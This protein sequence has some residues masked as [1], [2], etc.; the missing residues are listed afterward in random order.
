MQYTKAKTY[1]A[2]V[3][4]TL[5]ALMSAVATAQVV[6]DDGALDIGEYGLIATAVATLA[7][8]VYAVWRTP[9]Q[10]ISGQNRANSV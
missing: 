9:N 10:V 5:T 7:S 1:A 3:G 8:T 2:A 4:G 6:L